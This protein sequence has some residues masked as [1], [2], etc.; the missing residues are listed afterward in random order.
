LHSARIL[1]E[2]GINDCDGILAIYDSV[3]EQTA[4]IA[5]QAIHRPKLRNAQE[6]EASLIPPWRAC[7]TT[8]G[9]S[10]E[11]REQVFG[12]S[13]LRAMEAPQHMAKLI[14]FAMTDLMLEHK[15]IVLA[16]EDIGA[17]GGVYGVTQRLHERFG[18]ARV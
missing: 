5:E 12:S 15:E 14:N 3:D 8:N 16:G 18:S 2:N 10:P 17:K 11:D 6:V 1:V 9:P 7:D 13:D 4:R